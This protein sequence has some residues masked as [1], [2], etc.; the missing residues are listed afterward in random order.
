MP[1]QDSQDSTSLDVK[2]STDEA[3]KDGRDEAQ[4]RREVPSKRRQNQP[5]W[6]VSPVI[7]I[8]NVAVSGSLLGSV[9]SRQASTVMP[10]L[11]GPSKVSTADPVPHSV[12][13]SSESLGTTSVSYASRNSSA[14]SLERMTTS[15]GA[16]AMYAQAAGGMAPGGMGVYVTS[17]VRRPSPMKMSR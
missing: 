14:S 16:L 13:T 1:G 3:G 7:S 6:P 5:P 9:S 2:P 15:M 12:G 11:S 10:G 4:T 8:D 17:E